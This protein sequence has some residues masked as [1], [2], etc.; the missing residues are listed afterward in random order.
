MATSSPGAVWLPFRHRGAW[1]LLTALLLAAAH[2]G[3]VVGGAEAAGRDDGIPDI[4]SRRELMIDGFLIDRLKGQARLR[5]HNPVR[6]EISV[7]H[8]AAW[9]G[10][11]CNYH[12]VF[13]DEGFRETGRYR[14]YYHAWHIPSDGNQSHP[15]RIAYAE[16]KDGIRWVK[17]NLGLFEHGGSKQNNIVLAEI[18]GKEPHDFSVFKD[19]NPRVKPGEE[20]KAVGFGRNP[21]GLYAFKSPDGIH[22]TPMN[23]SKPVMTGHA[24]DTQ[25]LA[26]WDPRVG[27]YRSFV[28]DFDG[29]IRGVRTAT[30]DDLVHWSQR[31]WL[32]YPGAPVEQL[33]TNQV[34]PYYRAPH[35]LIG[36]PA[37]YVDRGWVPSTR[38]LPSL[39]LREQRSRTNK[40]YG[41]AVTDTILMTSRDGRNFHRWN[42]AFLRPGLRTRHNWAYGDNYMAWQ[43]VETDSPEDDSPRELSLYA[44]ESYFTGKTSRLRRYTLRIDGFASLFAPREGGELV[45]RAF[46]FRGD[47]LA[48]NV[49]TSAAGSVRVEIQDATGKPIPGYTLAESHEI[50]GDA[51]EH[52][53]E[54]KS[55][56][57]VSRLS[58][59]PIRLR[60][61]V[62]EAD[63][64]ALKFSDADS[65]SSPSTSRISGDLEERCLKI[66]KAGLHG[67]DFWPAIHAAEGLT[68]GQQQKTVIN[69]LSP[70]LDQESDLQKRCGLARELVRA[71]DRKHVAEMIRILEHKDSHGH[72]H[73]AESLYKVHGCGDGR[74]LERAWKT[75]DNMILRLMA[76]AALTRS[77][78]GDALGFVRQQLANPDHKIARIAAWIVARVGDQTDVARLRRTAGPIR[79]PLSRCYFD[80]ALALLGDAAGRRSLIQNLESDR[81]DIR[82]YAAVFA[83]EAR[84]VEAVPVLV[85]LLDDP[86]PDARLRSAQALLELSRPEPASRFLIRRDPGDEQ[87]GR[88]VSVR[89]DNAHLVHS[90]QLMPKNGNADTAAQVRSVLQQLDE[91]LMGYRTPR[92]QLVKLN[93]YVASSRVR[94]V[95]DETLEAWL[96]VG[97][98]PA[99]AHVETT[100]ADPKARVAVDAVFPAHRVG[101]STGVE[102]RFRV[103]EEGKP[104]FALSS[105]LPRG[106]VVY[107]SGQARPGSLQVA[108]TGTIR[109]L[110]ATLDFMTVR[111]QDIV[112]I[113][114]FTDP[115]KQAGLVLEAIAAEFPEG[116]VPPVTLV[117]WKS[118]MLPIEIEVVAWRPGRKSKE[119]LS[120]STPPG[121][122]SSPVFSRVSTIHGQ[123]RIYVSGLYSRDQQPDRPQVKSVF[124]QLKSSLGFHHS[125]FRHLAKA[126]YYVTTP[127]SSGELNRLRPSLYDPQRPPAASKAMV[128]GVGFEGRT[129]LIDMIATGP[130]LP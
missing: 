119:S 64:Y 19:S 85:N 80:H 71:G 68:L 55:T 35:L 118:G 60:F 39:K 126:T 106:E 125:D 74:A 31:D 42:Q 114:C 27:K 38:R 67:E 29:K 34:S 13:Y 96:P 90:A 21:R 99:V 15:L 103:G 69:F 26:F 97:C 22:W 44:T 50:F 73:A 98:R 17:P 59:T 105:V 14:M 54:W 70:K 58:G 100:L 28:R 48:V 8:N 12:T 46:R 18:N 3:A 107:V 4:G 113:K 77:G 45:T 109:G 51:L 49:A 56:S 25:N 65:S 108:T 9:E 47:R 79:D 76:A 52:P 102:Y 41:S 24:F 121:L 62:R 30:S 116:L 87:T 6:R 81:P 91:L 112:Q 92:S 5:L 129:I 16:S 124:D 43:M 72:V 7:V 75:S 101:A 94:Q 89:V 57:S 123:N 86:H 33:Y 78:R 2:D 53:V 37:R 111:R 93:V 36:F 88:P 128:S 95:V 20:Y 10:N 63:L 1:T 61:V 115:M 120:V 83:G 82:T 117:E 32:Q 130:D 84:M 11:G 110:L 66:L 23:G 122:S 104:R 40:R 127:G